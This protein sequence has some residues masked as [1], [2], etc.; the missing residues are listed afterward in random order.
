MNWFR[1]KDECDQQLEQILEAN[2]KESKRLKGEIEILEP[3]RKK[4]SEEMG[5][6]QTASHENNLELEKLE[7]FSMFGPWRVVRMEPRPHVSGSD[8]SFD[9][10]NFDAKAAL[11]FLEEIETKKRR[12]K[13]ENLVLL[14][15]LE[16]LQQELDEL[17]KEYQSL[18]AQ[19]E[20]VTTPIHPEV[21]RINFERQQ[22]LDRIAIEGR[23]EASATN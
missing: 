2:S 7:I 14:C 22:W 13:A 8:E 11:K 3:K 19:L 17:N 1:A 21:F 10:K 12:L 20:V 6:L 16:P 23:R 18:Q 15:K 5:K 4:L 9:H